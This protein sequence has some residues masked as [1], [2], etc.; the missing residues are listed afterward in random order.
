MANFD[1]TVIEAATKLEDVMTHSQAT[2]EKL[3][4]FEEQLTQITQNIDTEWAELEGKSQSLLAQI[5]NAREEIANNTQNVVQTL[6]QFRTSI[7]SMEEQFNTG[8]QNTQTTIADLGE[9]IEEVETE[10]NSDIQTTETLLNSLQELQEGFE[11]ELNATTDDIK[12]ILENNFTENIQK[13]SEEFEKARE[14]ISSSFSEQVI[15]SFGE[16]QTQFSNMI[17]ESM[18]SIKEGIEQGV[19]E[20]KQSSQEMT[21]EMQIIFD[22]YG[23]GLKDE[24]ELF[25]QFI[26]NVIEDMDEGAK[27]IEEALEED[28]VGAMK[29]NYEQA[30]KTVAQFEKVKE[31]LEKFV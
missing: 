2:Q 9:Q 21:G 19:N 18:T 20:S 28:L 15:P 5:T 7:E 23:E 1:D 29:D 22:N 27:E 24:Q 6:V 30:E 14:E 3:I 11:E 13:Q 4:S 10:F 31:Q 26:D 25:E 12:E 16:L 17:E 8:K